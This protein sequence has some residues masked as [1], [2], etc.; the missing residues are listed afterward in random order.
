MAAV[1]NYCQA[2]RCSEFESVEKIIVGDISNGP[3]FCYT[4]GW[5]RAHLFGGCDCVLRDDKQCS[6]C[7][8]AS[9]HHAWSN[10][11]DRL[12]REFAGNATLHGVQLLLQ[13]RKCMDQFDGL[14]MIMGV[15]FIDNV[16]IEVLQ[17]F[18]QRVAPKCKIEVLQKFLQRVAPK[19]NAATAFAQ[20]PRRMI[21]AEDLDQ[22][23]KLV[24]PQ[25]TKL[26]L[27]FP[28]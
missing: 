3:T 6:S 11:R 27:S 10:F 19:C 20:I 17:K 25:L 28:T 22:P 23:V 2:L 21:R 12:K 8:G 15:P 9:E 16:K 18:L 4:S 7:K 1:R 26:V 5:C 14:L 24:L 13:S